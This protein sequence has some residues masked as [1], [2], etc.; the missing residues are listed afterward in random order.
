MI[1]ESKIF[2]PQA[3]VLLHFEK[4]EKF[5]TTG[6]VD[7]ILI[8]IDP[9][10]A[11]NHSCPF[12][13]SGHIHLSKFKGTEFF[14]RAIM[15]E[16]VLMNLSKELVNMDIQ[17]INWTGG[18][19]PTMNPCLKNIIKYIRE[20][21]KIKMGMFSN[22]SMLKKFDMFDEITKSL[23]WIRISIDAGNAESYNKLR[24][25]NKNNDFKTV[26]ENIKEL[27]KYKKKI[28]SNLSIGAGFVV[29]KDN[30][31]EIVEFAEIFKDLDINYCQFKP[32]IVQIERSGSVDRKKEQISS[33]F[34][35][36]DVIEALDKAKEILGNKFE[37]NSYKLDDLISN[38]EN[39][40]R[41]YKQCLGSQ[42]QPCIGAD[43]NVYV[44]TN[45]RGHKNYAYG[46]ILEKKFKDIW[47]DVNKK[48][49]VMHQIEKIEKFSK[50]SQLCKPHESN[51]IVWTI[52]NNIDNK[53]YIKDIKEKAITLKKSIRHPEFI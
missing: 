45:H 53:Q 6:N 2:N 27:I 49:R 16:E 7:P 50:C 12:C 3:K 22:G 51:K 4:I 10:N 34:W 5:I 36:N 17:A 11:C 35:L 52:K 32:E 30:Y 15:K 28:K 21:S 9:S 42:L 14:N 26:I 8:E 40:G 24:V 19:E 29:T 41:N 1:I 33:N 43:G 25:T 39:Y 31:K 48:N 38:P 46:N 23:T 18:G 44:C 13:I 20:N 47:N 37:C